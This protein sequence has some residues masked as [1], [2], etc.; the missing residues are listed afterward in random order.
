[1]ADIEERA[2]QWVKANY[3]SGF[4]AH[5]DEGFRQAL[6]EAYLAG[7]AQTQRDYADHYG[8]V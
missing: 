3:T 5:Q 6:I 7:S 1:M 4:L 2:E 8:N